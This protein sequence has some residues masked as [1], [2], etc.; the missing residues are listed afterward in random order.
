MDISTIYVVCGGTS[1]LL[2]LLVLLCFVGTP[3]LSRF[4]S[5]MLGWRFVCDVLLST[6]ASRAHC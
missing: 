4:P 6:Q 1:V 3:P 2:C 5:S